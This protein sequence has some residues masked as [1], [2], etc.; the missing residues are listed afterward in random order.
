[1][2]QSA[3]VATPPADAAVV[4]ETIYVPASKDSP[5]NLNHHVRNSLQAILNQRVLCHTAKR[6]IGLQSLTRSQPV[7]NGWP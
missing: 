4:V 6:A 5:D 7:R 2:Q 3:I 1:M